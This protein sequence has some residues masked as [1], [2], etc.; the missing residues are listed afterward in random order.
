MLKLSIIS[1]NQDA[2]H[3]KAIVK[4]AKLYNLKSEVVD[5]K[6][7]NELKQKAISLGDIIYWR[8]SSLDI[9][10]ERAAS[11]LELSNKL[12]INKPLFE[13]PYITYKLYQ[14]AIVKKIC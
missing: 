5:F 12:V 11:Y 1:K 14:Q 13:S 9:Q 10:S 3:V 8:S 4:A 2:L 6:N 7:I